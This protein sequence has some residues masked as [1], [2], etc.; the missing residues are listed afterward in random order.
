MTSIPAQPLSLYEPVATPPSTVATPALNAALPM[1]AQAEAKVTF[2]GVVT[3]TP[4][5][6]TV[7]A[8]LVVPNAESGAAP[9]P[10]TGA[11]TV[12]AATPTAKPIEPV[13]GSTVAGPVCTWA[14]AV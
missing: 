11:V 8:I 12:T 10:S 6:D 3:G 14:V 1:P 7:T 13:T 5:N 9:T 2:C 4:P